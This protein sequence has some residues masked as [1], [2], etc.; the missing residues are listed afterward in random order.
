[1]QD[2]APWYLEQSYR[3][4]AS[5]N[6]ESIDPDRL[7][8]VRAT[9]AAYRNTYVY[10]NFISHVGSQTGA[11]N[12]VHYGF[13]NSASLARRG[14]LHFYNNTL[15]ILNDQSNSWR[16]R[17]FDISAYDE[18]SGVPA[19]ETV[20]VFN[21]I[22]YFASESADTAASQ[23]CFGRSSGTINLGLNW[24]SERWSDVDSLADCYANSIIQPTINGTEN[25]VDVSGAT[26]PIVPD[27]LAPVDIPTIRAQA[28]ALPSTVSHQPVDRQ[29]MRHLGA[30][31]RTSTQDLGAAEPGSGQRA[32][33]RYK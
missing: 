22:I 2:A 17:L 7:A 19:E 5:A 27:T 9:E 10:G 25:L 18:N 16:I 21:N 15:S 29:Y 3:E 20:D 26:M 6:G 23:F 14:T 13:D 33:P 30:V 31:S 32:R 24:V 4:W 28:Q 12:L 8:I 1:M 11:V